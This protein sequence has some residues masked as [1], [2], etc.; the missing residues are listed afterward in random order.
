MM[1]NAPSNRCRTRPTR[2][3]LIAPLVAILCLALPALAAAPPTD[4]PWWNDQWAH[5][6]IVRLDIPE[7]G[8]DLPVNFLEPT[9]LLGH[10]HLTARAVIT[11]E[12]PTAPLDRDIV[13]TDA[14]GEPVPSHSFPLGWDADRATVT[15]R[16]DLGEPLYYLYYGNPDAPAVRERPPRP[17]GTLMT[18]TIRL[19]PVSGADGP[20]IEDPADA[21][22]A[23]ANAG[24]EDRVGRP[25]II[26]SIDTRSNPHRLEE[27]YRYATVYSGL[28]FTPAAGEYQFVVNAGGTAFLFINGREIKR[29]SGDES[30]V[31]RWAE[32]GSVWLDEGAH[33]I[34]VIHGETARQQGIRLGWQPPGARSVSLIDRAAFARGNHVPTEQ[35]GYQK[36]GRPLTP[37]F[38]V[39]KANIAY[40][41][42]DGAV[43]TPLVL[44]DRT[45]GTGLVHRW[46][47]GDATYTERSP[48]LFVD[49]TGESRSEE[50]EQLANLPVS[51]EVWRDGASLGTY[52]RTINLTSLPRADL[53]A[54]VE[55][56]DSPRIIYED[57]PAA[58]AFEI[59]NR[60]QARFRFGYRWVRSAS[61]FSLEPGGRTVLEAVIPAPQRDGERTA[62]TLDLA[63]AGR[64]VAVATVELSRTDGRTDA[65]LTR[66]E[67][68]VGAATPV[69]SHRPDHV[70]YHGR[71][72]RVQFGVA[73]PAARAAGITASARLSIGRVD[74]GSPGP[75]GE[76]TLP[77]YDELELV[78][79]CPVPRLDCLDESI[80]LRLSDGRGPL[81]EAVVRIERKDGRLRA[82]ADRIEHRTNGAGRQVALGIEP[83]DV[84]IVED[85]RAGPGREPRL[86]LHVRNRR[87]DR[88][89]LA[90][91]WSVE[92]ESSRS[93]TL[94][95]AP[96]ETASL[97][98]PLPEPGPEERGRAALR[99][100]HEGQRL[101]DLTVEVERRD[102]GGLAG[103]VARHTA[104]DDV[105][106]PVDV[107][108]APRNAV[109][110]SERAVVRFRATNH[111]GTS[112]RLTCE[113]LV[114]VREVT[115]G[116]LDL[117]GGERR[118]VEV[119]LPAPTDRAGVTGSFSVWAAETALDGA[120]LRVV[121]P[122]RALHRLDTELGHLIDRQ[123]RKAT[124]VLRPEDPAE[125]RRWAPI[126]W[127]AGKL[128]SRP[129]TVLFYGDPMTNPSLADTPGHTDVL[130][131]RLKSR[132]SGAALTVVESRRAGPE[133]TLADLPAFAAALAEH[134]PDLV[135]ISPG[136][137]LART[138]VAPR[139]LSRSLH[140]MIEVARDQPAP[141]RV[142]LVAPPPLVSHP[143][144]SAALAEAVL[145]IARRHRLPCA[146]LHR[147]ITAES[148]WRAAYREPGVAADGLYLLYPNAP[149]QAEMA[150]AILNVLP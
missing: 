75:E 131:Q 119:P 121:R 23:L 60:S 45:P 81:A 132:R 46:R 3:A 102:D 109:P 112:A 122:G 101:I 82:R 62:V 68:R 73:N 94:E 142:V 58:A 95:L 77:R 52:E 21:A 41:L 110:R 140:A 99:L 8:D 61:G 79:E 28:L 5:R 104:T 34:T 90:R 103:T 59:R 38:T 100:W 125:H 26:N 114:P 55:L 85:F 96:D 6:K 93:Q 80:G 22:L 2:P 130:A 128:R 148:D 47:V 13:V 69:L 144:H 127:L 43:K 88:L 124:L 76:V 78:T 63:A 44:E 98:L 135:I 16:A 134:Q 25:D 126:K 40:Q 18:A 54:G 17:D 32:P 74:D 137:S 66:L 30:P 48:R 20:N 116:E 51:L 56:R 37:F 86:E 29:V 106:S 42:P 39:G 4:A 150:E 35:I 97:R 138:G 83:G 117:A 120:G 27:G 118:H 123:G 7:Q 1:M 31:G 15:F 33:S 147:L 92:G 143:E 50:R 36:Q 71:S 70:V 91:E 11:I 72:A 89:A 107:R 145:N 149:A 9:K 14:R 57:E 139:A 105:G 87:P 10:H 108:V 146:D 12:E 136:S 141:P 64:P 84:M 24:P 133:P 53:D 19:G 67:Q 113:W 111:T 129:S 49:V 115:A 65:R